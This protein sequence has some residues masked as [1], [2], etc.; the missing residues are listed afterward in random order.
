MSRSTIVASKWGTVVSSSTPWNRNRYRQYAPSSTTW[1]VVWRCGS[2]AARVA[3][4]SRTGTS[5][6]CLRSAKAS[7]LKS[8][9]GRFWGTG[10]AW[11]SWTS[12]TFTGRS[13]TWA[14]ASRHRF[15][16]TKTA[17]FK[18]A[19][20]RFRA[21]RTTGAPWW[22]W[23]A[24]SARFKTAATAGTRFCVNFTVKQSWC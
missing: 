21:Y 3:W 23:A 5:W 11:A 13:R 16:S 18:S 8:P 4:A 9:R 19:W 6:H 7:R 17:R 10:T 1:I 22:F 2:A 15:W 14:R 20:W 24:K 12:R